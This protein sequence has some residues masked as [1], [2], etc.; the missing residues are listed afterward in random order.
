MAGILHL[1]N[2]DKTES[3]R[4]SSLRTIGIKKTGVRQGIPEADQTPWE[5]KGWYDA[6][7]YFYFACFV[8]VAEAKDFVNDLHTQMIV[9]H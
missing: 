8:T 1:W 3:V 9:G 6:V 5:V 2:K 4:A 7:D